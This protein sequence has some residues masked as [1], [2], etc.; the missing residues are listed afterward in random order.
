MR[1]LGINI[2][3]QDDVTGIL[4]NLYDND[5]KVIDS[6]GTMY[7]EYLTPENYAG[8][9]TLSM[10][11]YREGTPDIESEMVPFYTGNFTLPVLNLAIEVLFLD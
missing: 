4:F 2:S 9:H 11:Y 5:E 6:I 7:F 10:S 8:E 1:G 3:T